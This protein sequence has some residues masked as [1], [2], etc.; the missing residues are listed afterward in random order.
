VFIE[1][2]HRDQAVMFLSRSERHAYRLNDGTLFLE[3]PR[4]DAISGRVESTWYWHGPTGSGQ[5]RSS[6]RVY[7]ATELVRL[8]V[9][10]GLRVESVHSGCAKEPF[11]SAGPGM[12]ARLGVL[13]VRE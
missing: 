7:S 4:F 13:A 3:E 12:S 6:L 11:V 5:K 1:T 10:V 2:M 8:V 9:R